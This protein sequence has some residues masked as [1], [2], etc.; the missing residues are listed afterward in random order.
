[1]EERSRRF[2]LAV[3]PLVRILLVRMGPDRYR[4]MITLHH[5]VLDGWSLPILM[6]EL[7]AAYE[8]GGS[9]S[10]LPAVTPYRDYLEWLSRQDRGAAREAWRQALAGADEPSLIAPVERDAELVHGE[11]VSGEADPALDEALRALV[12][13]HGVTLNTVVQAGWG[14]LVAKLMGRRDVVFGASVA[15]RPADLP[16]MESMLGLFINTVPVRVRLDPAQT[17]AGML[18]GLQ[19]EQSAL[20]DYQYLSLSDIQRVAGT[21]A[22]FD[23]ILAFENFFSGVQS[24]VSPD[25]TEGDLAGPPGLRVFESGIRES[26]N[27]PLGLIA[28]PVGGLKL[29]LNYRPD[30]FT[31]DE[32]QSILDRLLRL[33]SRLAA[34]PDATL[35]RIA[36]VDDDERS[37]V[38][39]QWNATERPVPSGSFVE[40]F[41]AQVVRTPGAVAVVGDDREWSYAELQRFADRVACGL[42]ARGVGRGDYV[43]V[44]MDRSVDLVAVLLGV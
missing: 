36:L 31:A 5:I 11:V 16:G 24:Q 10:G 29:R 43:G 27:Y 4:M 41:E 37:L 25:S 30:L 39:D 19:A 35:A 13:D 28:G 18:A 1:V 34:N 26:I 42:V 33:L 21:G 40:L 23:T 8:A 38:V 44:V 14:L 17:V 15:G 20:M 22:N 9:G 7:W 6:R 12:R 2:D 3:P 32:A